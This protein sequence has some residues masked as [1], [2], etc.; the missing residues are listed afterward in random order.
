MAMQDFVDF[1]GHYKVD[2]NDCDIIAAQPFGIT[3]IEE[4][5]LFSEADSSFRGQMYSK[6]T[7]WESKGWMV[8]ALKKAWLAAVEVSAK[9]KAAKAVTAAVSS[10]TDEDDEKPIDAH[11]QSSLLDRFPGSTSSK[12]RSRGSET[13]T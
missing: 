9:E 2:P 11:I 13:S 6:V 10:K 7:A 1:M 5:G 8:S 3:T 12:Y 4:Y